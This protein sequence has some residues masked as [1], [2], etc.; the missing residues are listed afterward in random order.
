MTRRTLY[1]LSPQWG[2]G[3]GGLG[4]SAERIA[5]HLRRDRDVIAIA[6][7]RDIA[8]GSY[9]RDD[10]PGLSLIRY[11]ASNDEKQAGQ[12]VSDLV[13]HLAETQPPE[14]ILGFYAAGQAAAAAIAAA[15]LGV[16]FH[17]FVRGNDL[18]LELFGP[19][20]NHL[21]FLFTRASTVFCVSQEQQ[22]KIAAIFRATNTIVVPNGVD[23]SLFP[24]DETRT[25]SARPV[26]GFFGEIKEKKGLD[27]LLAVFDPA[28]FDLT[29]TGSLRP[30]SAKLLHGHLLL[31]PESVPAIRHVPFR[32]GTAEVVEAYH[33]VDIVCIPSHHEGMPNVLL[34]AMSCE[35]L[36]VASAVGGIPDV[37]RDRENGLLFRP[38]D[39]D[40]LRAALAEASAR[41]SSGDNR[42]QKE[43]RE[44]IKRSFSSSAEGDAYRAA[45]IA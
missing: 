20:A 27:L 24:P 17:V 4:V 14:Q 32:K 26:I 30:D 22:R 43:A 9:T 42:L 18:D 25:T 1:F 23:P 5:G 38:R 6:P 35:K 28:L 12:F 39:A 19:G 34:E 8:A 37:V 15:L 16:P 7:E 21:P 45:L 33:G 13:L 36:V 44:T 31:Q 40:G 2:R 3:S 10:S 29:I 11:G 41:I